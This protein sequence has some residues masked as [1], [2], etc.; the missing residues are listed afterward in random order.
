[1]TQ[2]KPKLINL[3]IGNVAN[4]VVHQILEE[5]IDDEN[6]RRHYDKELYNSITIAKKYREKIN[7]INKPFPQKDLNHIKIKIIKRANIELNLRIKKGYENL[8]LKKVEPIT[9]LILNKLDVS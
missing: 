6:L 4:A 9:N 8:D 5:A 2:N 7:P 3:F 1:M